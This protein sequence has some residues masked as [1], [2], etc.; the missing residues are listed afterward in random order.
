MNS[1][2]G[3]CFGVSRGLERIPKQVVNIN[4]DYSL[5]CILVTGP[6]VSFAARHKMKLLGFLVVAAT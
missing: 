2:K 4:K 6:Q 3:D 1:I 5:S